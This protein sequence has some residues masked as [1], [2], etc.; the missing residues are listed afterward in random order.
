MKRIA[1][2]LLFLALPAWAQLPEFEQVRTRSVASDA[3]LLD[4]HGTPLADLRFNP[5]VRRLDWVRLEHFSP[6]LREALIAGEDHRFFE[7]E[8]V[9]WK[10]VVG[11]M[12]HNLWHHNHRGASTLTMQLAGLLDPALAIPKKPGARRDLGQKW[13]QSKAARLLDAHWSKAQ[14][15]EAYLNLAPFRGDL[16]GVH[17]ASAVLFGKSPD[18]LDHAESLLIA[19]ILPSPNARAERIAYRACARA[20]AAG[21]ANLCPRINA[22]AF[23]LDSPRNRPR[24]ALAPHLART[25][26]KAGGEHVATTLDATLQRQAL[27]GLRRGLGRA[28]DKVNAAALIVDTADGSALAWVGNT[29]AEYRDLLGQKAVWNQ[30]QMPFAATLAIEKRTATAASLLPEPENPETPWRSLRRSVQQPNAASLTALQEMLGDGLT[31]KLRNVGIAADG[32]ASLPGLSQAMRSLVS[33][34]HFAPLH[35]QGEAHSRRVWRGDAAFVTSEILAEAGARPSPYAEAVPPGAGWRAL[36]ALNGRDGSTA[37]LAG[38]TRQIVAVLIAGGD[39]P[40]L[41]SRSLREILE[42]LGNNGSPRT[43]RGVVHTL[44][45]FDPPIE[46]PR[47]EYFLRGTETNL[48]S[49]AP[50]ASPVHP[51]IEHPLASESLIAL[52]ADETLALEASS[53]AQGARWFA[54]GELI[55]EGLRILWNPPPGHHRLELRGPNGEVWDSREFERLLVETETEEP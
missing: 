19:A 33:G 38:N 25:A 54:D 47:R 5:R 31:E 51:Q 53:A 46:A 37:L 41:A 17:A 15:L 2:I 22:L 11:A 6:A 18:Q 27:E 55:G 14:I 8:G 4:R 20:K 43:P 10:A 24:F 26:L 44:V 1:L 32:E 42:K 52:G 49:I 23:R 30:V 9:D 36:W 29:R 50:V 35:W 34:G 40:R 28:A 48:S 12:W 16:Q 7:H 13:D 21:A 3:L 45:A 39:A